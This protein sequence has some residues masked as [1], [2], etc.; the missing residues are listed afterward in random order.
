MILIIFR[1]FNI[2]NIVNSNSIDLVNKFNT[3]NIENF[4]LV[5]RIKDKANEEGD[6][7][8]KGAQNNKPAPNPCKSYIINKVQ[9]LGITISNKSYNHKNKEANTRA[10]LNNILKG[11]YDVHNQHFILLIVNNSK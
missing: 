2:D 10:E 7:M 11:H 8:K 5:S 4:G 3:N 6:S 1:V 9:Q